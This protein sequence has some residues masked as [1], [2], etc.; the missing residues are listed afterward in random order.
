MS[1]DA[2]YGGETRR[3]VRLV[4]CKNY[5][6]RAGWLRLLQL[7]NLKEQLTKSKCTFH[8]SYHIKKIVEL[9]E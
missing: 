9:D 7:V 5:R 8:C 3:V 6:H 2:Q 4:K 1:V